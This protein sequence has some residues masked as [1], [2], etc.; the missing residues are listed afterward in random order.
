MIWTQILSV[1]FG[2]AIGGV[3][4]FLFS[5]WLKPEVS[6][7]PWATL[8]VNLA[9]SFLLG[10]IL[11]YFTRNEGNTSV[12][13]MLTTGFCGGFTTF[14]AFSMELVLLLQKNEYQIAGIYLVSTVIAGLGLTWVGYRL[15]T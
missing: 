15:F 3:F 12:K 4:R 2:A 11:S 6:R 8:A 7:F 5:F 13:L 1:A 14:S 9:G 10:V